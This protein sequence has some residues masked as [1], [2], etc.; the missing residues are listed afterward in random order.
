MN[1]IHY[2]AAAACLALAGLAACDAG[3]S[4][5]GPYARNANAPATDA[6][7]GNGAAM[8]APG[9]GAANAGDKAAD[10]GRPAATPAPLPRE[11][12]ADAEITSRIKAAMLSDPGL[13]GADISVDTNRGVV[14]LTGTVKSQEQAALASAHA[15]R[16]DGVMRVD[17]RISP[18]PLS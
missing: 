5:P 13:T 17:N 18:H 6:R 14:S 15:Q 7:P 3:D 1:R 12:I 8:T 4:R 11:A 2:F 10:A 16:Q 9:N